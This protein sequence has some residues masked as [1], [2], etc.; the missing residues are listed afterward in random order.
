PPLGMGM[1]RGGG[2]EE[3]SAVHRSPADHHMRVHLLRDSR[4]RHEPGAAE[5]VE[6]RRHLP[7]TRL[8]QQTPPGSEPRGRPAGHPAQHVQPIRP[9]VER[10]ERF[11]LASLHRKEADLA[12]GDVRHIRGE[13]VDP[14]AQ[15]G[16]QGRIQIA[17]VRVPA[18]R[19][20]VAAGTA[21]RRRVDVGGVQFDLAALVAEGGGQRGPHRTRA[22]AQVDDDGGLGNGGHGLPDKELGTAAGDEHPGFDGDAQPRELGPAEDEFEGQTRDAPVDHGGGLVRGTGGGED[23]LRLVL[24]EDAAGGAQC[25]DDGGGGEKRGHDSREPFGGPKGAPA[26]AYRQCTAPR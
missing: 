15:V 3:T 16:R 23:Q 6:G 5:G 4:P 26:V 17:L 14:T 19:H 9:T 11:V 2:G 1:G 8:D 25:R 18:V 7:F 21:H 13:D 24:G 12:G 22:T 20:E 10:D